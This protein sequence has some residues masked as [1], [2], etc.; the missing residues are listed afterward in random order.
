MSF[1]FLAG[2]TKGQIFIKLPSF[3]RFLAKAC[4]TVLADHAA[5][6][7]SSSE[8]RADSC[9]EGCP[10][11]AETLKDDLERGMW[12]EQEARYIP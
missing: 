12:E 5:I 1:L 4:M 2:N 11:A 3:M 8:I 10:G 9:A 7:A 6:A